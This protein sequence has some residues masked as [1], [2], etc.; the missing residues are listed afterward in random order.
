M[1]ISAKSLFKSTQV[2]VYFVVWPSRF[3]SFHYVI[4]AGIHTLS[5][6]SVIPMYCDF[7]TTKFIE[8]GWTLTYCGRDKEPPFRRRHVHMN[9]REW[10]CINFDKHFAEICSLGSNGQYSRIQI[11]GLRRPGAKSLSEPMIFSLFFYM[12]VW[13]MLQTPIASSIYV[14]LLRQSTLQ[15]VN[16]LVQPSTP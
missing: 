4:Q 16:A 14:D 13:S 8:E 11:M 15:Y 3:P 12:P 9:F 2:M 1:Y 6:F 10:K 7:A 5:I